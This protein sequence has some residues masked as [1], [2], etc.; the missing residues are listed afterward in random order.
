MNSEVFLEQD[1]NSMKENA[2]IL[3]VIGQKHEELEKHKL[4][5]KMFYPNG[6]PTSEK[7]QQGE[8]PLSACTPP[9]MKISLQENHR[10]NCL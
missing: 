9:D 6:I 8:K 1:N 5:T 4:E 3:T 2:N 10:I 7:A